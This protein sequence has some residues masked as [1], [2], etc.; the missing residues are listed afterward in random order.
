MQ[1]KFPAWVAGVVAVLVVVGVI[2]VL[3]RNSSQTAQAPSGD[4][5]GK[6]ADQAGSSGQ[7][8][9]AASAGELRGT[10][11]I[12]DSTAKG[13]LMLVMPDH[14]IYLHTSRDYSALLGKAVKLQFEGSLDTFQLRDI[15]AA[16]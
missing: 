9:A 12:S 14:I 1:N 13:N 3:A 7:N 5:S 15:T 8:G 10:L 2:I 11:K 6:P 16:E 4:N